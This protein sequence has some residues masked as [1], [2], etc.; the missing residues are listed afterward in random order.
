MENPTIDRYTTADG[1]LLWRLKVPGH[2]AILLDDSQ[3]E[4]INQETGRVTNAENHS[5]HR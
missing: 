3:L 4:F 2:R 5:L 1:K